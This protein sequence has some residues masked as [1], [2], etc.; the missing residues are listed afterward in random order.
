MVKAIDIV[1]SARKLIGV[2]YEWWSEG[3]PIPLWIYEYP[4]SMPPRWWFDN[5]GTMCSDLINAARMDNGLDPIGGT[6]AY[7]DWMAYHGA[8]AFDAPVPAV[9]G[10]LICNPGVWRGGYGQGHI[11]LYTDGD[12][13]GHCLIQA[14]DGV[15]S[16]AGVNEGED[17]RDTVS[18]WSPW[19]YGL[20][21]DV[22]YSDVMDDAPDPIPALPKP[23]WVAIDRDGW[24]RSD[25]PDWSKGWHG[26]ME[27]GTLGKYHGPDEA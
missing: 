18:W 2:W 6:P 9:P 1:H 13:Y 16:F 22:D 3:E 12:P 17:D 14:T 10:A 19:L 4:N 23:R 20:M 15:G 8:V 21:P 7:Y 5:N 11:S 26:Y 27:D 25:G 24:H